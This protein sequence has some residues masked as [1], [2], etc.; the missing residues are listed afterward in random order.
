MI[1]FAQ[2]YPQ[3]MNQA[4]AAGLSA[5]ELLELRSAFVL[6]QRMSRNLYR[7]EGCPLLNHLVRTASI[8]LAQTRDLQLTIV[9]L[10]HAVYVLHA[11]KKKSKFG[12]ATPM[13]EIE[14]IRQR[15]LALR[16]D[17]RQCHDVAS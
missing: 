16:P 10:L 8:A 12:I 7:A 1:A 5:Q 13:H 11:F 3:L 17:L 9:A 4:Q 2:N 6:A 15:Y 14:L